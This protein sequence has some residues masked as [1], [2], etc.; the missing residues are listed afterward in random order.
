MQSEFL[1]AI[2]EAI[3]TALG[4]TG[5]SWWRR[6]RELPR[7]VRS[8]REAPGG[9]ARPDIG[10]SAPVLSQ[11]YTARRVRR[12]HPRASSMP[13][14]DHPTDDMFHAPGHI[15]LTGA[16]GVGKTV[17]IWHTVG[18][19][20][21]TWLANRRSDH[22][23]VTIDAKALVDGV[24]SVPEVLHAE[25]RGR[26]SH[27]DFSRP[28]RR[29]RTWLVCV[30]GLD[31]IADAGQRTAT[32]TRLAEVTTQPSS[33]IR[34]LV[35][36]RPLP[37][38]E[39]RLLRGHF[40]EYTLLEFDDHDLAT[41]TDRW[42]AARHPEQPRPGHGDEPATG[43]PARFLAWAADQ[44]IG[45]IVHNPLLATIA[46]LV[47]ERAPGAVVTG[48]EPLFER[49]IS[50]LLATGRAAV[51]A[52][53]DA[54]RLAP[55]GAETAAWLTAHHARLVEVAAAG[56]L[57]DGDAVG[58]V[59][60]WAAA[61]APTPPK[62]L[63]VDWDRQVRRIL[64]SCGLFTADSSVPRPEW[65]SVAEYLAA[66]P[67]A[68]A[69]RESTWFEAM[70]DPTRR[71]TAWYALVRAEIDQVGFLRQISGQ[72][73]G[74]AVAGQLLVMG[75]AVDPALRSDLVTALL[76]HAYPDPT[77]PTRDDPTAGAASRTLLFTL[78]DEA[79]HRRVVRSIASDPS[80]S[81]GIRRAA[82][83]FLAA[84]GTGS[85]G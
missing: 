27:I 84:R 26:A 76:L 24:G 57:H 81:A 38:E 71:R 70:A 75:F 35:V 78:A 62:R 21:E 48:L 55:D 11:I 5:L 42:F 6:R 9:P 10:G 52:T 17:F 34:L 39:L 68:R 3:F 32:L 54:I 31:A 82:A 25:Y 77:T 74:A 15:L 53:A 44:G 12:R 47:W 83:R 40:H 14:T 61:S 20:A 59:N 46:V 37:A 72:A 69:W 58:A 18:R 4:W 51:L 73:R 65:T 50:L 45:S 22:A 8:L 43:D 56:W 67:L 28:P 80:R 79:R 19:L 13:K 2:I 41:F 36:A 23:A 7:L 29:A 30:D 49:F 85:H 33:P 64:T 66:G 60:R 1:A 16:A 63:T